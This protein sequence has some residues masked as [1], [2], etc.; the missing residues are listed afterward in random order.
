MSNFQEYLVDL[1]STKYWI[2]STE[3]SSFIAP[4]ID[5]WTGLPARN[6]GGWT[7]LRSRGMQGWLEF[8]KL[9][10]L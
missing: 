10:V 9:A 1:R 2:S 8:V 4:Y 3:Y 6:S 5:N 7:V